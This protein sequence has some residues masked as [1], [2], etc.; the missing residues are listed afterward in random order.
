MKGRSKQTLLKRPAETVNSNWVDGWKNTNE[1]RNRSGRQ[2]FW[3]H[4]RRRRRRLLKGSKS[5]VLPQCANKRRRSIHL[6]W[7]SFPKMKTQFRLTWSPQIKKTLLSKVSAFYAPSANAATNVRRYRATTVSDECSLGVWLH[8]VCRKKLEHCSAY[9]RVYFADFTAKLQGQL[10]LL[11]HTKKNS[12]RFDNFSTKGVSEISC[13][14]YFS[15][16][17]GY[18]SPPIY[19]GIRFF[20]IIWFFSWLHEVNVPASWRANSWFSVFCWQGHR[21][22]DCMQGR[23]SRPPITAYQQIWPSPPRFRAE[24]T[25]GGCWRFCLFLLFFL[26]SFG[27][28]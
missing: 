2:V 14:F 19:L 6:H 20:I 25:S 12:K 26:V 1:S 15:F 9:C 10:T 23:P 28:D 4:R 3:W 17:S 8:F 5:F 7:T 27:R 24:K 21:N 16:R 11:M 18:H 13:C 22:P